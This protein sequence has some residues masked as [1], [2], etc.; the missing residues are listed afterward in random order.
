MT[1]D[2][3]RVIGRTYRKKRPIGQLVVMFLILV[4]ACLLVYSIA[5]SGIVEP[6]KADHLQYQQMKFDR[7]YHASIREIAC[8]WAEQG[9]CGRCHL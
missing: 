1:E 6:S 4:A 8:P 7:E 5:S 9:N 2:F 3:P